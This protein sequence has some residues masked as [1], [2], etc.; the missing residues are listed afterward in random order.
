MKTAREMERSEE[1]KKDVDFR[2]FV[3]ETS[4]LHVCAM[5]EKRRETERGLKGI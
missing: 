1:R 5:T 4:G 2:A 3:L